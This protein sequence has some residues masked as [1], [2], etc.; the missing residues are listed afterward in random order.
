MPVHFQWSLKGQTCSRPRVCGQLLPG[1]ALSRSK[2]EGA[3]SRS[4]LVV[5]LMWRLEQRPCPPVDTRPH[6]PSEGP[7]ASSSPP[8]SWLPCV[9]SPCG[10]LPAAPFYGSSPFQMG[11]QCGRTPG[12]AVWAVA[13]GI[14]ETRQ[15]AA[16]REPGRQRHSKAQARLQ[17]PAALTAAD[18][19]CHGW[20]ALPNWRWH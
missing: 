11:C 19:A 9:T 20:W 12:R 2:C 6:S 18:R 3:P 15:S 13:Q 17:S 5:G 10:H 4:M 1:M 16:K 7:S 8:L 14:G